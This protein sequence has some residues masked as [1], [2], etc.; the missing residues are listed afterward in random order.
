D[1][2]VAPAASGNGF[3]NLQSG[4]CERIYLG[5]LHNPANYG[6][7]AG[8]LIETNVYNGRNSPDNTDKKSVYGL[9]LYNHFAGGG[10]KF[11]IAN[12]VTCSGTGDCFTIS[13]GVYYSSYDTAA[14][15]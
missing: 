5:G 4:T 7:L 11:G 10:Q 9:G 2:F 1:T 8:K 6:N 3:G 14:G 12:N 13:N 15:D